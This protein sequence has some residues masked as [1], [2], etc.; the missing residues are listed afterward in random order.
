MFPGM[1][2]SGGDIVIG[3]QKKTYFRSYGFRVSKNKRKSKYIS[4]LY[5]I[6]T[7]LKTSREK[8]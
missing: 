5:I 4:S 7:V 3:K 2:G 6:G 8:D 1:I